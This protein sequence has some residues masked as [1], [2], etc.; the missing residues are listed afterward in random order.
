MSEPFLRCRAV[1][2]RFGQTQ[3]V[4]RVDLEVAQ[5]EIFALLGPSGCGKTTLLRLIGG[6]EAPDTGEIELDGH[7][8]ASSSRFVPAEKRRIAVVFQDF[9][10]FPHMN[11]GKNVAFGLPNGADRKR[12][13]GEL[14]D[15]VGL[16]GLDGRM[17]HELSGGQQQRVALARALAAEP[18]LMLLDE[19]FSNLDPAVRQ[20]VRAEVKQ[21]IQS[22]G[23]TAVFV[24][25]DQE[26]A[27][28]LAERVA[29]MMDGCIVQSG[30]PAAIY[31]Q[32]ATR[33]VAEFIGDANFLPAEVRGGIASCELGEVRVQAGFDGAAELMIRAEDLALRGDGASTAEVL[34]VE[35]YGHDQMA[36]V[37][38]ASGRL[39]K[40]RLPAGV[41]AN[42]GDRVTVEVAGGARAFPSQ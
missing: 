19:P 5:G 2:K 16:S 13:V 4:D 9:A 38:S 23:I 18:R 14:L 28:S 11:V 37:R 40:V 15:L 20:R 22:V 12:R 24:T 33:P 31:E 8:L 7:V 21:L 1:S 10:L 26:E 3:A 42:A 30:E 25:H 36:T 35:Y 27:L 32:P 39:L 6:F 17:P 41:H 29:V 34:N